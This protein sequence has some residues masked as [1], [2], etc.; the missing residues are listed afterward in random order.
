MKCAKMPKP[1]DCL[2]ADPGVLWQRLTHDATSGGTASSVFDFNGDGKAEV[3]YRDEC[4]LRVMNG[5]D[6]KTVF[7]QQITSGTAL[8]MPV[9][10][11]V[12]ND[13]H[14]DLVVPSDNVQGNNYCQSTPEGQT[15]QKF[16]GST[17]GMFVLKDPMNRWMPSRAV[18]N[19]HTYHITNIN[20]NLTVPKKEV[21]NWT[22]WNNYRQNVQGFAMGSL[23]QP[24]LTGGQAPSID[25][26]GNDCKTAERLWATICYRG[27][28]PTQPGVPATFYDADPRLGM[29]KV[30]CSTKTQ[31]ALK[32]GECEAVFCDWLNPPQGAV[33]VWLRADDDGTNANFAPECHNNNDLLFLPRRHLLHPWLTSVTFPPTR[34]PRLT[35]GP[36]YPSVRVGYESIQGERRWKTSI[37]TSGSISSSAGCTS[38]PASCGSATSGSSTSSMRRS[39]RP[40]T[41]TRRRRSFP[42]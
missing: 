35:P 24:D 7:A 17:M 13:G 18:W 23:P 14:A 15:G 29:A 32:P 28:A 34:L 30:L 4:W 20:D 42:S 37:T 2:G 26:G 9:V 6:G 41:P 39:P 31:A 25:N 33:D 38:S 16:T 11:D 19:Q 27:T 10:A 22:T 5:P 40:M 8:E 36:P 1:G 12:D 3:V 21:A